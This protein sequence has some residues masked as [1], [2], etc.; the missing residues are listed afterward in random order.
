MKITITQAHMQHL[1]DCK[2]ALLNSKLGEEYFSSADKARLALS[3]G[4]TKEEV[5]VAIDENGRCLGFIWYIL[6]GAFHSFPYVHI[7]AVKKEFRGLGIGQQLLRFFEEAVFTTASKVF[8][9]VADFNPDAKRLYE[10]LGY[11]QVGEIQG[12]YKEGVT[13]YLMMKERRLSP[14]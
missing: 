12:L 13:E 6:A 2:A 8:L 4:I 1:E 9:V 5:F 10:R 3:E 7:I 11:R 14:G